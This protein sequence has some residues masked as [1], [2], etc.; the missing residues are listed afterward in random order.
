MAVH[1]YF[2]LPM[3]YITISFLISKIYNFLNQI[4][5]QKGTKKRENQREMNILLHR[6]YMHFTYLEKPDHFRT[7]CIIDKESAVHNTA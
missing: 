3:L 4:E 6:Y 1:L 5:K 2:A 7:N